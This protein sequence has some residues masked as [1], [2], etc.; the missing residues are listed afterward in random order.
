MGMSGIG[1]K[2]A[3]VGVGTG[4][5]VILV[6]RLFHASIHLPPPWRECAFWLGVVFVIAGVYFWLSSA[7]LVK[8]AFDARR[9]VTGGVYRLSRNPMYA[10]FIVFI[11]QGLH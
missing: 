7:L 5:I 2:I 1:P 8:R 3:V 10:A 4:A 11:V 6:D 9:L